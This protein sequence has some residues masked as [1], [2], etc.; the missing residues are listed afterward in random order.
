M[1][2]STLGSKSTLSGV[3]SALF[4]LVVLL[5]AG[6]LFEALPISM[7]AAMIIVAMKDLLLQVLDKDD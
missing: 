5:A 4:I 2:L 6:T 3:V 7:L 1:M